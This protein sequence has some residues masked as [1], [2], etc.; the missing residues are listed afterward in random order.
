MREEVTWLRLGYFFFFT[1]IVC[2]IQWELA[3]LLV[4][5]P[6]DVPGSARHAAFRMEEIMAKIVPGLSEIYS[7]THPYHAAAMRLQRVVNLGGL[8]RLRD[9][10]FACDNGTEAPVVFRHRPWE[11]EEERDRSG[12]AREYGFGS[13]NCQYRDRRD[14]RAS[15]PRGHR[16]GKK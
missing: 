14:R 13:P 3:F 2:A 5:N 8:C 9:G 12:G 10:E 6:R 1:R 16:A 11:A 15:R 4:S 7:E